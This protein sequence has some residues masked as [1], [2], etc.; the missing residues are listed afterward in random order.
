MK[1]SDIFLTAK[2]DRNLRTVVV[3]SREENGV[4]RNYIRL[5]IDAKIKYTDK[6]ELV[7]VETD[8]EINVNNYY[9]GTTVGTVCFHLSL[10][11]DN[12]VKTFIDAIKKDS[13]V[14]FKAICF[15]DCDSY[16]EL[17]ITSHQLYARVDNKE[18]FLSS[19]TGKN[20]SA[21]PIQ[22]KY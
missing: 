3:I 1:V 12:Y 20:N 9:N 14:Y 22:L 11:N 4:Q 10:Y 6:T 7:F 18:Y 17:G 13:E 5:C 8:T 16:K 15:N 2:K 21:S 19:Y